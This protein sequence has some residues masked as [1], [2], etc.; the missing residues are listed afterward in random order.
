MEYVYDMMP[1]CTACVSEAG[2][3][4]LPFCVGLALDS[5]LEV[6]IV[7]ATMLVGACEQ[8]DIGAYVV[9]TPHPL[10]P[11]LGDACMVLSVCTVAVNY[12]LI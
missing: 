2:A 7:R 5:A 11:V 1:G 3:C 6:A 4:S 10:F 12:W 8:P 9:Y